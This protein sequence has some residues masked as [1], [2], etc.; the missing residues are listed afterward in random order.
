[1]FTGD[2]MERSLRSSNRRAKKKDATWLVSPTTIEYRTDHTGFAKTRYIWDN[3]YRQTSAK[4][5]GCV[6]TKNKKF[7]RYTPGYQKF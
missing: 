7:P 3:K 2:R 6:S 5:E 4:L 1:M